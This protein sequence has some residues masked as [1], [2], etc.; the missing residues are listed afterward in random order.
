MNT[1][2]ASDLIPAPGKLAGARKGML[3]LFIACLAFQ[4][5]SR[6]S[7][8]LYTGLSN[9]DW[10]QFH[11][12]KTCTSL[13]DVWKLPLN[14]PDR[15]LYVGMSTT[16]FYLLGDNPQAFTLYSVL[17]YSL[18]LLL[19]MLLVKEITGNRTTTALF[20]LIFAL[21]PNLTESFHWAAM[22][23]VAYM[24][25]A[26]VGSAL[27]WVLYIKH[28]RPVWL[29]CSVISFAVA[30]SSYEFGIGLP[31]VYLLLLPRRQ[32]RRYSLRLIP[33]VAVIGLYATWK[34][35]G[36]FGMGTGVYTAPRRPDFTP[37]TLYWNAKDTASWWLMENMLGSFRKGLDAFATLRPW[38]A[39]ILFLGDIAVVAALLILLK[40]TS[41]SSTEPT[42][43]SPAPFP[44][45]AVVSFSIGWAVVSQ[46]LC[47][48]SWTAGRMNF[49]PAIGWA[50]LAAFLLGRIPNK[51]WRSGFAV[52]ALLCL[53]AN[54][55]TAVAWR[56]SATFQRRLYQFL[57]AH[58][59]ELSSHDIVLFDTRE[60]RQRLTPGLLSAPGEHWSLWAHYGNAALLRGVHLRAMV[61]L[62]L[63]NQP[64]P[65]CMHDV[66][67][68]ATIDGDMLAW[69]EWYD[70]SKPQ[71]SPLSSVYVV[72]CFAAGSGQDP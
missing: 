6:F 49:T 25:A 46:A 35:T 60:L 72:D 19:S 7:A 26:Y 40:R 66:E 45:T 50:L 14:E 29:A 36:C 43:A 52:I 70:P 65:N 39:R 17:A 61:K 5:Y 15:P 51:T 4:L 10:I 44:S 37:M 48:V 31:F 63:L 55:G 64:I 68:G 57:H 58:A 59:S 69:H 11:L 22:I 16:A 42:N 47:L 38:P 71:Q 34:L 1:Q 9:D 33:F 23:T 28:N 30:I 41:P 53:L 56:D 18:I 54:Q 67:H 13:A 8:G 21:L 12:A 2:D 3:L 32:W 20:G 27:C 62:V 24:Q